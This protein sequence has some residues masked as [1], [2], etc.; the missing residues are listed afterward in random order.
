MREWV[1]PPSHS[2]Q[3]AP[4]A[5]KVFCCSDQRLGQFFSPAFKSHFAASASH[6]VGR[7][8]PHW[9]GL[10]RREKGYEFV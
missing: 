5:T 4:F 3:H 9:Q 2:M 1:G 8:A 7:A 10:I 6:L